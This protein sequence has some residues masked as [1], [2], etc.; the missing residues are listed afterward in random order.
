MKTIFRLILREFKLFFTDP[1]LPILFL[2]APIMYGILIGNVYKKGNV[3]DLP[4]IVVDEDNTTTSHR[5]IEMLNENESVKVVEVLPSAFNTKN[6][7][8]EIGSDVVVMIPRNFQA[9]LQQKKLPEIV[10]FVDGSN[11]LTSNTAAIAVTTVL[12]TMKAG[13]TIETMRKQ[14]V[15]EYQAIQSYEP[16]KSTMIKQNIR[17][18]NYLYFMLPGVLLTVL[19]QVL[20]LGLALTFAAEFERGTFPELVQQSSNP[21]TLIFVK[22]FP[23]VFMSVFIFILYY[24][25]GLWYDMKLDTSF[26][27]FFWSSVVFILSVCF[28]GILVSILLP[29]QLKATEVLMVVA[30]PSFILSGFTWPMSQMPG[31]IQAIADTIPLTHYLKIFRILFINKGDINLIHPHILNLSIIG[32]ICFVLSLLILTIKI[33]KVKKS[34]KIQATEENIIKE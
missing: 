9:D 24:W 14:G 22:T 25:Y 27:P 5:I 19:Q 13:I 30:T 20:L 18:G 10:Y 15:P 1:V 17:S 7:A 2:G 11:T 31:W 29:S 26:W 28:M 3:T 12:S 6:R 32:G 8:L 16:F 33:Q 21:L 4:I 23:Y 34:R